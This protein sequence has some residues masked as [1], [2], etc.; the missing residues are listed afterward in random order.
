[1]KIKI[2]L[3]LCI[4]TA[5]IANAQNVNQAINWDEISSTPEQNNQL[6]VQ[7]FLPPKKDDN[8]NS[9]FLSNELTDFDFL[10]KNIDDRI[11]YNFIAKIRVLNK[12]TDNIK[13][14]KIAQEEVID[15][16]KF[17]IAVKSCAVANINNVPNQ[18]AFVEVYKNENLAYKGWMSNVYKN[19]DFPELREIYLNLISCDKSE[20]KEENINVKPVEENLSDPTIIKPVFVN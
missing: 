1:M 17:K 3:I 2:L 13:E 15:L 9:E 18:L 8:L 14:Y 11:F 6:E 5:N 10:N 12:Y 19:M 20:L 16:K 7:D 4:F